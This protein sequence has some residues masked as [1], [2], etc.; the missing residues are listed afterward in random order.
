MAFWPYLLS[1]NQ[2]RLLSLGFLLVVAFSRYWQIFRAIHSVHRLT[3]GEFFF[4]L[5][6]G[7]LSFVQ[8]HPHI[9]TAALLVM[10]LADGLAAVLGTRFGKQS[11]YRVFGAT[12]SVVG[13]LTFLVV[14]NAIL[15]IYS[16]TSQLLPAWE[17]GLVA[18]GATL[19]E[20]IGAYGSDN[21]SVPLF[22]GAI[23]LFL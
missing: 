10:S 4:A 11:R 5:A 17:V 21:L 12:K 3:L 15:A 16:H 18:L 1:W 2:I 14:A 13:T 6:V 7:L 23:L 19:L 9:Y 8:H 20:N 22:V